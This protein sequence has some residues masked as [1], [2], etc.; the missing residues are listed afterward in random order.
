MMTLLIKRA[1]VGPWYLHLPQNFPYVAVGWGETEFGFQSAKLLAVNM[2]RV[3]IIWKIIFE[4]N[5]IVN[6]KLDFFLC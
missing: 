3:R 2:T 6:F 5:R 4:S 1:Q